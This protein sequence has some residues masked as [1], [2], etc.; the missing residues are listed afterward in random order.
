MTNNGKPVNGKPVSLN[1]AIFGCSLS[2]KRVPGDPRVCQPSPQAQAL[3]SAARVANAGP[4]IYSVTHAPT[5]PS[6][7]QPVVVTARVHDPDGVQSLILNY[8]LDPATTYTAVPMTDDGTGGDAIA[9]DGLFSATIPG[10]AS[11]RSSPFTCRPLT[12][13][14]PPPAFPPCSTIMARSANAW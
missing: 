13:W 12:A 14:E 8:R 9:G 10:Q 2:L 1:C 6:A 11:E 7:S 4:A 5:L 3:S